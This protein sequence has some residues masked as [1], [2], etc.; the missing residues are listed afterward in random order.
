MSAKHPVQTEEKFLSVQMTHPY[1]T[2]NLWTPET[3]R[4]W[5]VFHGIGYLSRYFLRHFRH[6]DPGEN[7]II[8]PQ[9]PSLY[10]L[11]Q[12][13]THIGASWLTRENTGLHM[14]NLTRLLDTLYLAENLEA[15][16]ALVLMGYSQGVSVLTRWVAA[17]KLPC[18]RLILYAG[19]VPDPL[20]PADFEHLP[21]GT[22]VEFYIGDQDPFVTSEDRG[23]LKERMGV[24][25]GDRLQIMEFKGGHELV[26]EL[27]AP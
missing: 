17:R 2:L 24:L 5:L 3:K 27:L 10:Y 14:E 26:G 23:V 8:A 16:P 15:A 13:Y 11:D 1:E 4:V 20:T 18:S 12:T 19:R 7:Y 21:A 6:L 22:P 25:F 9:A